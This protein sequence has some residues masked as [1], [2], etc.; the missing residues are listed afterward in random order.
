MRLAWRNELGGLTF[1][2]GDDRFVKW[3]PRSAGIDLGRERDRLRWLVGRHPVPELLDTGSDEEA[4]W[5]V[6]A[7]LP[8][9]AA[10]GDRWRARRPEAI[11]A[12]ATGL[13]TLHAVDVADV[14]AGWTEQ[15]WVGRRPPSLGPAPAIDRPVL[16]HGDACAPNTL[17]SDDGVWC[18][19][20]DV[21]DLGVGDR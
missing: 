1:A 3:S 5:L 12:I 2:V 4:E 6:T 7:A 18:G 13:R 21:G 11:R 10:V 15:V 16:V 19:H 8:G 14:P 20:V 17:V 9:S